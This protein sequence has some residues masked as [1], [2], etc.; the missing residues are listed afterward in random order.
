M[1]FFFFCFPTVQKKMNLNMQQYASSHNVFVYPKPKMG[2]NR[3][4]HQ[5]GSIEFAPSN[6]A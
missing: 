6:V 4:P 1:L 5:R 3:Q 2:I